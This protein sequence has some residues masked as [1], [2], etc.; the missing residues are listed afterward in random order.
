MVVHLCKGH[1]HVQHTEDGFR[2]WVRMTCGVRALPLISDRR[3]Q[4]EN[5]VTVGLAKDASELGGLF[6]KYCRDA[7]MNDN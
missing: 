2:L 5:T 3:D 4:T 6:G 1:L 7:P